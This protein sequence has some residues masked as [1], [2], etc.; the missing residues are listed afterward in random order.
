M[1]LFLEFEQMEN[2]QVIRNMKLSPITSV[3]RVACSHR[4]SEDGSSIV[5]KPAISRNTTKIILLALV[6]ICFVVAIFLFV[7]GSFFDGV[8]ISALSGIF[9][10]AFRS[11][12]G[13]PVMRLD[14]KQRLI[15]RYRNKEYVTSIDFADVKHVEIIN[16]MKVGLNGI[17]KTSELNIALFDGER[18]NVATGGDMD[19]ILDQA[20]AI[21]RTV[22]CHVFYDDR[23][24]WHKSKTSKTY[25]EI[26]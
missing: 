25:S 14:L 8:F 2:I 18:F 1:P 7:K 4:L 16:K 24:R 26:D 23:D 10:I 3:G 12:K 15:T 9:S 6:V 19:I 17:F 22:G 11:G 13:L 21:A 20:I 5:L